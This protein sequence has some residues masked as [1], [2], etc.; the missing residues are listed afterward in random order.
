MVEEE[1]VVLR[2]EVSGRRHTPQAPSESAEE[3]EEA[4]PPEE[5]GWT[6]VTRTVSRRSFHGIFGTRMLNG[7]ID[8]KHR[9]AHLENVWR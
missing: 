4:A 9:N 1:L 8:T 3:K 7:W 5:L 6:V 2:E